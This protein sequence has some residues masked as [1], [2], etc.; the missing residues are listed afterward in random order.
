GNK[1]KCAVL[2]RLQGFLAPRAYSV[3][4]L[5]ALFCSLTVK[6]FHSWRYGLLDEY[7]GWIMADLSVLI[8]IE[9]I[10]SLICFRWPRKAVVRSATIFAAI[11]CTWSVMNAGWLIRT[12]TQILPGNLLPLVR[13]PVSSLFIVGVNLT[14]MPAAAVVLL[15][16]SAIAL[17]FFIFVLAKP[18]LPVYNRRRFVDR[19]IFCIIIVMIAV[20]ARPAIARRGSSQSG[21][22]GLRYNSHLRAVMSLVLPDHRWRPDPKRKIPAFDQLKIEQQPQHV[23]SNLVVV[24][25]EGVQY[26]YTSLA[27][28]QNNLTPYL[29]S[30]ASQGIELPNARSS[31]THTTKALFALL[32]GRFASASQDIAEA[33]PVVKTY[34]SLATILRDK[35]DYRSAFFQSAL[36][37]F[38]SRPGLV[39]NLGYDKFWA[40]DDSDDP[41]SFLG[42]LGCDEF[43]MLKPITEWIKAGQQPFFLT[44]LCSVTHDPYEVPEWFGT[45]AKEPLERYQQAIFYTDKFLAE[46][47]VVFGNLG[48]ADNT[49]L[50]VIGDHG[51][52]FG[53]H[54]LLGHER[55]AFDEVLRI[56]FCL[57]APFLAETGVKMTKPVSSIDLTPTLLGLLGFKTES[58]GFDGVDVLKPGGDD[59]RVYFSGWMQEGPAGFIEGDRKFIYNPTNKTT[60]I[61]NLRADPK[62]LERIELPEQRANRLA[63]EIIEWRKSTVF[64]LEQKRTGK[65]ELFNHWICRWTERVSSTKRNK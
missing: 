49:I 16:P 33:V 9:V 22:V 53:E 23:K 43:A 7:M 58:A 24:I 17:A 30:L 1:Y 11:V 64:R 54:G 51:E 18:K 15:A 5:A 4:M 62:E 42:Y 32:T 37:S 55:I 61:Y 45:P 56:P 57:R 35:L 50:C 52:A 8:A 2:S 48:I 29:E 13:A 44:V 36:G 10:L 6:L 31:L 25:L 14:K 21:S 26:Q 63:N 38:E 12:G 60:C 34:A 59:R 41:N 19:I 47:D 28:K 65:K 39:H 20:I 3:I 46:L 40:R 27:N